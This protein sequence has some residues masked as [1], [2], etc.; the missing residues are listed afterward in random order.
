MPISL[1]EVPGRRKNITA[2]C[3]PEQRDRNRMVSARLY[4]KK[5]SDKSNFPDV[6]PGNCF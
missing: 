4:G 2:T 3:K 1:A 6:N 5:L